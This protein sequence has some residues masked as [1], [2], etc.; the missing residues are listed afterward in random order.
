M[1]RQYNIEIMSI[2]G[3]F[4]DCKINGKFY[5]ME[6]FRAIQSAPFYEPFF[7]W[8]VAEGWED[9]DTLL[10]IYH[11]VGETGAD[12]P[13]REPDYNTDDGIDLL[14]WHEKD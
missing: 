11:K 7:G 10:I 2:I 13:D 6:R 4:M 9:K 1:T 12:S 5:S 14:S 3:D 8:Y